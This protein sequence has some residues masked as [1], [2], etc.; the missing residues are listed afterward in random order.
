MI[1]ACFASVGKGAGV[2]TQR[3]RNAIFTA[4]FVSPA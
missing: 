4:C 2:F 3:R 1:G